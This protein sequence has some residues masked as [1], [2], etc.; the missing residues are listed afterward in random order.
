VQASYA[1]FALVNVHPFADGNGRVAR[2]LAS[3]YSYRAASIPLVVFA[4]RRRAYFDALERAD[5]G[6][7]APLIAYFRERSLDTMQLVG[8]TLAKVSA[9]PPDE[10]AENLADPD[11][12][13]E[14]IALRL[15][16]AIEEGL[17]ARLAGRR[18][19]AEVA[20]HVEREQQHGWSE[21]DGWRVPGVHATLELSTLA[22]PFQRAQTRFEVLSAT[23]P[24][25]YFAF[26]L[27]ATGGDEPLD[28]RREQVDPE[29][30]T[31]FRL[32]LDG[33]LDRQLALS[34]EDLRK[35]G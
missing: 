31:I 1:H 2:A 8:E 17:S 28:V 15:L 11:E 26:R 5:E 33:W 10:V 23:D 35:P 12:E 18:S 4:D 22:S 16:A 24:A 6:A 34:L 19:P 9:R 32:R 13:R 30:T 3:V 21:W 27:A 7:A 25:A 14:A 20:V 29:L